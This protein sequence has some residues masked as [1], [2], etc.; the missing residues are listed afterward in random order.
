MEHPVLATDAE[1]DEAKEGET[2]HT[3]KDKN[4]LEIESDH[5]ESE[6]EDIDDVEERALSAMSILSRGSDDDP[7]WAPSETEKIKLVQKK[8]KSDKLMKGLSEN[9][10]RRVSTTFE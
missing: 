2:Q 3:S 8:A 10:R 6:T 9:S 4:D 7:T 5:D 1:M